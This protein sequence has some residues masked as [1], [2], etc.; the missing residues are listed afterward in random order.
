MVKQAELNERIEKCGKILSGDPN[1]QIFA[2]LAD[3][4]RKSGSL[5]RAFGVCREGLKIHPEYGAAHVVMAKI[6]LDRGMYDWAETEALRAE[7][8]SGSSR[9][10]ELLLAEISI[11]Q[12][13]FRAA[14]KLL[15]K[16][17]GGD[18]T[19][20]HIANLLA[21]AR[22]IPQEQQDILPDVVLGATSEMP[23]T[24]A[25]PSSEFRRA[26]D[27]VPVVLQGNLLD[28]VLGVI[29][30]DSEGL[31][32]QSNCAEE[33]DAAALAANMR[34]LED[35]ME[36]DLARSSMGKVTKVLIEAQEVTIYAANA[37]GGSYVV[38]ADSTTPLGTLRVTLDNC[39]D[40]PQV[41]RTG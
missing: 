28:G 31:V 30:A 6:N 4:L 13:D 11:Y 34:Q 19:N 25:E 16:L 8:L 29:F 10:I 41:E 22:K 32:T 17:Q 35:Q 20:E 21:I 26:V 33:I 9:A 14:S 7:Q 18:P 23:V 38:I 27:F 5:D 37:E 39:L 1:S 12:G 15:K 40:K 3:A 24:P 2:A 36:A